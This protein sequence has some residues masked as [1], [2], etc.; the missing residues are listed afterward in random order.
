MRHYATWRCTALN[1]KSRAAALRLEFTF[2]GIFYQHMIVKGCTASCRGEADSV[3]AGSGKSTDKDGT[4]TK[5]P[6][7]ILLPTG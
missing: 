6:L 2:E 1:E 4:T 3:P 7:T 5:R